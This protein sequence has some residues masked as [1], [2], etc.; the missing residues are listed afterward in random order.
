[1]ASTVI[2]ER[3]IMDLIANINWTR[4]LEPP[5]GILL[6]AFIVALVSMIA[7]QWRRA[8]R[9]SELVRLKESMIQRGYSAD[10]IER[11]EAAAGG[12]TPMPVEI[13]TVIERIGTAPGGAHWD[14][15]ARGYGRCVDF[16]GAYLKHRATLRQC[17]PHQELRASEAAQ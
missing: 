1:M 9:D 16:A 13:A 7:P 17:P 11:F 5:A 8:H 15:G 6:A 12:V 3:R 2:G 14:C 4:I 10:E